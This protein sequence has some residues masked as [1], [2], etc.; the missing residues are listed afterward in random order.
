VN[1]AGTPQQAGVSFSDAT[2]KWPTLK[3]WYDAAPHT[4]VYAIVPPIQSSYFNLGNALYARAFNLGAQGTVVFYPTLEDAMEDENSCTSG[5]S[6][7]VELT[8]VGQYVF[9][10]HGTANKSRGPPSSALS[11]N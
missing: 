5:L 10:Y 1:K 8:A 4:S 11:L 3:T 7:A 2:T 6:G 9:T